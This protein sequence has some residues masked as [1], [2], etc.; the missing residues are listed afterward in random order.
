[1]SDA[2]EANAER[3]RALGCRLNRLLFTLPDVDES[4]TDPSE[5]DGCNTIVTAVPEGVSSYVWFVLHKMVY[6]CVAFEI[7]GDGCARIDNRACHEIPNCF[8][9]SLAH[10]NGSIFIAHKR[11]ATHNHPTQLILLNVIMYKNVLCVHES[12]NRKWER[13]AYFLERS[14]TNCPFPNRN[15][16]K[17]RSLVYMF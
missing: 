14:V 4:S 15:T 12:W 13:I 8:D 3:N 1:M 9:K 17:T 16:K 7:D 5:R 6:L 11:D 2:V 10:H